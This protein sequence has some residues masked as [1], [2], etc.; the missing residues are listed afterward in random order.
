MQAQLAFWAVAALL[1]LVSLGIVFAPLMR[2]G[3]RSGRRASYDMQVYRD[4]LRE[5]EADVGRGVLTADEAAATR[6]EVARRL[7]AAADAEAA[8]TAAGAAPRRLSR[9]AGAAMLAALALAAGGAYAWLGAPGLPDQPLAARMARE[10][11]AWASRPGQAEVEAMIAARSP[12]APAPEGEDAAMVARLQEMLEQRPGDA[13]GH[14]VLARSLGAL[15]RWP[16]ARA[17]QARAVEIFG[18]R[19]AARDLVELAEM[20][21]SAA[22]GYVSPEAEAALDRALALDPHDPIGR[23]YA[24]LTALQGGRPDIAERI[25]SGLL[26]EGPPD[27]PWIAAIEAEIGALGR[28]AGRSPP[29]PDAADVAAAADMAPEERQAMVEGMVEGLA[30]RLAAEGGPP[31]DWARLIRALGVLGRTGQAAEIWTEARETFGGDPAA[32]A[33]IGAAAR[34]AGLER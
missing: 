17:A 27:A 23:Y 22:N 32:L 14:R 18:E 15:G 19:A 25:W 3:A 33:A 6:A 2:G 21:I 4:Q 26:A 13:E 30:G 31:E 5:I 11:E 16:E 9:R 8:E 24:G 12:A 1:T 7:L 10:A 20:M 34:D 28:L 29:G